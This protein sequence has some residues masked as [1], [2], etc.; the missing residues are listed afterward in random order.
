[1]VL[2]R[3]PLTVT[4]SARGAVPCARAAS[5]R[6]QL[7]KVMPVAA[8]CLRKPRRVVMRRLSLG[9]ACDVEVIRPDEPQVAPLPRLR[10]R[11]QE[12]PALSA[13]Q[14]FQIDRSRIQPLRQP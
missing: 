9:F 14:I 1:M 12:P 4:G 3:L 13:T 5:S 11:A 2:T 6:P 10:E 8:A 7:Q